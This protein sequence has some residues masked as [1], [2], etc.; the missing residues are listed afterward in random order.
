MLYE[1]RVTHIVFVSASYIIPLT[2]IFIKGPIA[3]EVNIYNNAIR[4]FKGPNV[5]C[6][7][8]NVN[9]FCLFYVVFKQELFQD[10]QHS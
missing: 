8:H 5:A 2:Y 7:L 9:L 6:V 10:K 3:V 1:I 4:Y